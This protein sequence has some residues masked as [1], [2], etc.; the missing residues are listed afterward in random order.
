MSTAPTVVDRPVEAADSRPPCR[1]R[2][3][4][5]AR[6][7]RAATHLIT[8][9]C[10]PCAYSESRGLCTPHALKAEALRWFCKICRN[11]LTHMITP[12]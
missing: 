2:P 4:G 1:G 11:W 12:L 10:A 7:T 8:L 9:H 5:K 3:R 6:C